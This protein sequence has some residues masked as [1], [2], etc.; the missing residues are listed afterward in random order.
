[1]E[2]KPKGQPANQ[3]Y[4]LAREPIVFGTVFDCKSCMKTAS[5]G[6][7]RLRGL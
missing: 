3:N 6:S 4:T 5:F 7:Y 1:M 2:I